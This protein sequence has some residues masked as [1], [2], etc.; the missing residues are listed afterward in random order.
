VII[1]IMGEGQF[2][3]ADAEQDRLNELDADVES[4]VDAGDQGTFASALSALLH[5]VRSAGKPLPDDA[6]I[7]SDLVL[8]YADA[9][10]AEVRDLLGD[11]GLIPG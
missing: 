2:E 9:S 7:G 10:L 5:A 4:A 3:V 8:P 1:R 6:L 11:E